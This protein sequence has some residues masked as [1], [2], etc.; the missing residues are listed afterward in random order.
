MRNKAVWSTVEIDWIAKQV[1]ELMSLS[2]DDIRGPHRSKDLNTA[3][4]IAM[5][6]SYR[7]TP[8]SYETVGRYFSRN[9]AT[10][11]H[12]DRTVEAEIERRGDLLGVVW[13]QLLARLEGKAG[14]CLETMNDNTLPLFA[15]MVREDLPTPSLA[16]IESIVRYVEQRQKPAHFVAAVLANDLNEAVGRA[17]TRNSKGLAWLVGFVYC[18]VP[19]NLCGS[20]KAI[21]AHLDD[22]HRPSVRMDWSTSCEPLAEYFRTL[23]IGETDAN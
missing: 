14:D 21:A 9:H 17:D 22:P 10:V 1:S 12:A 15:S 19:G 2:L 20:R 7:Y 23:F 4:K 13:S 3:R 18:N 16:V 11:L 5:A 6:L 8:H